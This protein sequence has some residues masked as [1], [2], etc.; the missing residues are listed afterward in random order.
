MKVAISIGHHPNRPGI[1]NDQ[2][3]EHSEMAPIAGFLIQ[4]LIYMGYKPYIVAAGPLSEKIKDVNK[5]NAD[6]AIELHLNAGGGNGVETLYCPGSESG[7][8][9]AEIVHDE[10]MHGFTEK[11]DTVMKSRGIK[12]GWYHMKVGG[13]KDAF[14]EQ[15]NCPAVITEMYFLD[16][17]KEKDQFAGNVKF[18]QAMA[19]SLANAIH[20]WGIANGK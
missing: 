20:V 13:D 12:E 2:Y 7:Y 6:C 5:L 17:G 10:I 18:Y 19:L 14:L 8:R 9:L 16:N 15:T 11:I 4:T 3:T 1:T